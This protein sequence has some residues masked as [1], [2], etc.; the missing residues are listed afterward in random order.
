MCERDKQRAGA[1]GEVT[2]D[3]GRGCDPSMRVCVTLLIRSDQTSA[4]RGHLEQS[5]LKQPEI[6]VI[7][8]A[9]ASNGNIWLFALLKGEQDYFAALRAQAIKNLQ[10]SRDSSPECEISHIP[11]N[12]NIMEA[13]GGLVF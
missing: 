13:H 3:S 5:S 6:I 12:A 2:A 10:G 11:P 1:V 4:V 7:A 8:A 9:C